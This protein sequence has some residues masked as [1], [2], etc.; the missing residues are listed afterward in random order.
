[1]HSYELDMRLTRE[2]ERYLIIGNP[3]VFF[4]PAKVRRYCPIGFSI[5]IMMDDNLAWSIRVMIPHKHATIFHNQYRE[6]IVTTRLDL[7]IVCPQ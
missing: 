6:V 7:C 5:K 1:M 4:S 3:I 2:G